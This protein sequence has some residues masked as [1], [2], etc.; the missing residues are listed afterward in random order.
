MSDGVERKK[1]SE[2]KRKTDLLYIDPDP[3]TDLE[4]GWSLSDS[5]CVVLESRRSLLCNST[6]PGYLREQVEKP[7]AFCSKHR[8]EGLA[9]LTHGR[10]PFLL[11]GLS[12]SSLLSSD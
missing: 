5:W 7:S 4:Q 3:F 8:W 1:A 9:R 10:D 11:P 6:R 2:G 12:R